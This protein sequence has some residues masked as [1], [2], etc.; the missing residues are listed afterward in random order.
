MHTH[1]IWTHNG[2]SKRRLHSCI[3][4]YRPGKKEVVPPLVVRLLRPWCTCRCLR[5]ARIRPLPARAA[6]QARRQMRRPWA[7]P[8]PRPYRPAPVPARRPLRGRTL[9]LPLPLLLSSDADSSTRWTTSS[10]NRRSTTSC[11]A[12]HTANNIHTRHMQMTCETTHSCLWLSPAVLAVH[13]TQ[14][15]HPSHACGSAPCR[16]VCLPVPAPLTPSA[17]TLL[18]LS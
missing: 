12:W 17:C 9:P 7:C 10:N 8:S 3:S 13:A 4:M 1:L 6:R 2:H 14:L 18:D 16:L 11:T 5:S 15:C